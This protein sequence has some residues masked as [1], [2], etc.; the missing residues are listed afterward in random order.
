MS[1]TSENV[2]ELTLEDIAKLL[3]INDRKS[4]MIDGLDY[5][6]GDG[7]IGG[8]VPNSNNILRS[9]KENEVSEF[10]EAHAIYSMDDLKEYTR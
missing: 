4:I 5:Y 2:S 6:Y 3:G 8:Y 9:W 10:L 1:N 7:M